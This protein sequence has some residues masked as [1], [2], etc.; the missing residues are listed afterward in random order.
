M[1]AQGYYERTAVLAATDPLASA[2]VTGR[3]Y[4]GLGNIA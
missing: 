2:E 4:A 3:A 1:Q